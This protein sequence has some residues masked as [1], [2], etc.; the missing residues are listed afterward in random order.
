MCL[1]WDTIYNSLQ[2]D[3][4]IHVALSYA[5]YNQINYLI[6]KVISPT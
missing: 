4:T 1:G 2:I 6:V 3:V 5:N